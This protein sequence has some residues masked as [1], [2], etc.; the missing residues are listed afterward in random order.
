MSQIG[1]ISLYAPCYERDGRRT[2]GPDEDLVTMAAAAASPLAEGATVDRVVV[3]SGQIDSAPDNAAAVLA[4]ALDLGDASIELRRGG[5]PDALDALALSPPGTLVVTVEL[6][7]AS[8]AAAAVVAP[9]TGLAHR[10][11]TR[12][13][14]PAATAQHDARLLRE[15][16]WRP[17]VRRLAGDAAPAVVVG[18]PELAAR[19]LGTPGAPHPG[20]V[21][22]APAA[23]HAVSALV[24]TGGTVVGI[25]GGVA[26]ALEVDAV[27]A[28]TTVLRR[29]GAV[30]MPEPPSD[31][32]DV[33]I[34]LSAFDRAFEAKVGL[35][36][37]RC[38]CGELSLPPRRLCLAC[39]REDALELVS[40]RRR[41]G[42]YSVV[43]VHAPL[44]GRSVPYTLAVVDV[45]DVPLRLL[46]PVTDAIPGSTRIGTGGALVL[47]C[48]AER[49]GVRDYGYAFQP[50]EEEA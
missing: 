21:H 16:A 50:D 39:G 33:P 17:S 6:S 2:H 18:V 5:A 30:A 9:G 25:D 46:A 10:G 40:L 42:V 27:E 34:S 22:G 28:P 32:T 26:S 38:T 15:R 13:G 23:L 41:G 4:T 7:S 8:S 11:R 44:P 3:V 29:V 35:K 49:A 48:V 36:A 45:A 37:A 14:L 47:R 19:A 12:S 31:G 20:D 43:T 1:A 24:G